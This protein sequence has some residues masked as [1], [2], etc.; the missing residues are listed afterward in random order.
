MGLHLFLCVLVDTFELDGPA[1]DHRVEA[2]L[3]ALKFVFHFEDFL[4]EANEVSLYVF[5]F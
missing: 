3:D 1:T 5:E 4:L 2:L